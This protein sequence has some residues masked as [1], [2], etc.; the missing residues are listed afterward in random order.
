MLGLEWLPRRF[1]GEL[2]PAA[3]A[4]R[5]VAHV[6]F[7]LAAVECLRGKSP[8]V[9]DRN[10]SDDYDPARFLCRGRTLHYYSQ[11]KAR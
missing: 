3:A 4:G 6:L 9:L 1:R 7:G 10:D 8:S 5:M 11:E 2:D